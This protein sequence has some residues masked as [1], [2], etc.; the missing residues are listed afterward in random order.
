MTFAAT[1]NATSSPGSGA[2]RTRSGS[3]CGLMIDLFGP[4]PAPASP[5]AQPGSGEARRTKGISGPTSSASSRSAA[6]QRSL[7]SRL[8][9]ALEGTGSPEYELTW[10]HWDMVSGPPICALRAS[11]RRTSGSG[12]TGWPTP[13]STERNASPETMEKRLAFRRKKGQTTVPLYLNE[14]AQLAGWPTARQSDGEKNV[15]TLD[16]TLKEIERKGG[17]QDLCQAAQ[18]SGWATPSANDDAS[19]LPGAKM[20]PMLGAQAKLAGVATISDARMANRGSLNPAFSRWLMEFPAA[21]D[22]CVPTATRSSRKSR[23]NSSQPT[24]TG[25]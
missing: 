11:G 24:S 22:D 15:R 13:M 14:V 7:E 2:G 4:A 17:P 9:A 16:G 23:Q 25:R 19:G 21:W 5:S 8:R 1:R 10:K 12:F 6:L 3:R 20:Q 18:I